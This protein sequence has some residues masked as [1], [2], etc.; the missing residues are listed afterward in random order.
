MIEV[1]PR[2]YEHLKFNPKSVLAKIYGVF[3]V[4]ISEISKIYFLMM[5]NTLKYFKNNHVDFSCYDLKGSTIQREVKDPDSAILKDINY[6]R[7]SDC[8]LY[9]TKQN[10]VRFVDIISKDL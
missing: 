1:L 9:M 3:A 4:E 10:K 6:F 7:S 8:F 2:Y 5:E